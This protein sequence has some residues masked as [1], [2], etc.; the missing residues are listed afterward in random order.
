[1]G[2]PRLHKFCQYRNQYITVLLFTK[3][4]DSSYLYACAAYY[5]TT[6]SLKLCG[7]Q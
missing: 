6:G 3:S 7:I 5:E 4:S 2:T 1:M